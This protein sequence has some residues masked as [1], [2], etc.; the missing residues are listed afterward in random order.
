MKKTTTT[1]TS[2]TTKTTTTTTQW[3]QNT[4]IKISFSFNLAILFSLSQQPSSFLLIPLTTRNIISH[5]HLCTC[6]ANKEKKNTSLSFQLES[7]TIIIMFL[8]IYVHYRNCLGSVQKKAIFPH[9]CSRSTNNNKS[10]TCSRLYE[11]YKNGNREYLKKSE[12]DMN[13][14]TKWINWLGFIFTHITI[15][16]IIIL[17]V[18]ICL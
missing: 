18:T 17:C 15:I 7:H 1:I 5:R 9:F 4:H 14:I 11:T 2:K 6:F 3:K 12:T 8:I 16:I 13:C 10:A